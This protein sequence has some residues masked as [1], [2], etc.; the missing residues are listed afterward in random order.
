MMLAEV[1]ELV[2][3][4]NIT[5]LAREADVSMRQLFRIKDGVTDPGLET[6]ERILNALGYELRLVRRVE[7][8]V[9]VDY[10]PARKETED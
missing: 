8:L 1:I 6:T 7:R 3:G 5:R 10:K 2:K 9:G 4:T